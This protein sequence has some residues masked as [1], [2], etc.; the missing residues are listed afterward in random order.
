LS[1]VLVLGSLAMT[2]CA[3]RPPQQAPQPAPLSNA[4][5]APVRLLPPEDLPDPARSI[6]RSR[7]AFHAQDMGALTWATTVLRY[8]LVKEKATAIASDATLARPLTGDATELNSALPEKFFVL[9]DELRMAA[10][11][12][13]VAAAANDASSVAAA[14][15]RLSE[16]CVKC[17]ATY[18]QGHHQDQ[19]SNARPRGRHGW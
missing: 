9:Q 13:A 14:Y 11:T 17:H 19:G 1:L 6:L 18:R 2:S 7:M 5:S 10:R 12:L 15:G 4:L 8:D 3:R 16:T